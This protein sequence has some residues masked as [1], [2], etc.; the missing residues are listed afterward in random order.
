M[1]DNRSRDDMDMS[2]SDE[3][4]QQ[5]LLS[6]KCRANGVPALR[7]W[8]FLDSF[9]LPVAFERN[10]DRELANASWQPG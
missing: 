3:T 6:C 2:T 1:D 7:C 4:W 9:G 10:P 8:G 5:N